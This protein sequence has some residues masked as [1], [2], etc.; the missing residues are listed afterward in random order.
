MSE[1]TA[2]HGLPL[3]QPGQAQ[4]ELTHNEALALIDLLV[5]PAVVAVGT[6]TPPT[7]PATG[8]CWIIGSSPTGAWAGHAHAL[9]GWTGGGWRFAAPTPGMT[10]WIGG[11]AGFARWDGSAWLSGVLT[12]S[13]LRIDGQQVVGTRTAAIADPAGGATLDSEARAV[14][15]QILTALR[16]HGLV[17]A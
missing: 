17:A 3:I 6:D 1:T 10:I 8:Q 11:A 14:I 13:S 2:R 12:A 15:A 7:T 16:H 9:A 5:Q 4:K